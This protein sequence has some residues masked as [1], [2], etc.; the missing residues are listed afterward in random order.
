MR[1]VFYIMVIRLEE[2]SG[3]VD[4]TA[5]VSDRLCL[6]TLKRINTLIAFF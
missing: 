3:S 5:G 6:L 4:A 1:S 2:V